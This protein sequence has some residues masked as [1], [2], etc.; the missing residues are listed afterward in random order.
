MPVLDEKTPTLRAKLRIEAPLDYEISYKNQFINKFKIDSTSSQK[1]YTWETSYKDLK[2]AGEYAPSI[3]N[4]IPTAIVVPLKFKYDLIGSFKNWKEFGNW[5]YELLNGLSEL[6]QSEKNKILDI[7][8]E[9]TNEEDKIRK[10]YHYLQD[11]TRYINISIETGGLK[12]YPAAYVAENKYGD[13]KALTNY[14]KSVLNFIG[15]QS[16]YTKVYAGGHIKKIDKDFPSQQSNHV[17]LYV[18]LSS[19]TLWID[20]TSDDPF[21][22]VGTF[23]QNREAFIIEKDKSHFLK[24]PA[25]SNYDVLDTRTIKVSHNSD[26][27]ALANFSNTY[28]GDNFES[29]AYYSSAISE[30]RK[31]QIIRNY[32]IEEGFDVI[33]FELEEPPRN[34]T[35]I[36]LSYSA[37]SNNVYKNYGN[38]V[39][40]QIL[41]FSI[42]KMEMPEKR[43]LPVNIDFPINKIDTIEYVIPNGYH[44]S[45]KLKNKSIENKYGKYNI[46]FIQQNNQ[47]KVIKHF[48]LYS[49]SYPLNEYEEFYSFIDEIHKQENKNYI[50]TT[51]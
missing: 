7:V 28:K 17:I 1:I 5:Q 11:E 13:C 35:E 51:K 9:T 42:P 33:N 10:L 40:I 18:P 48:L 20:C 41:P 43:Q 32:Y 21:N 12:P 6:P 39:I 23:I 2:E 45:N 31:L 25:L 24:T 8:K 30:S 4:L 46:D 38:D 29:L 26:F 44:V 3:Y 50:V 49:G 19:D 16:Y 15:I 37:K 27:E 34:S 47:V 14:F 36:K 22:Y